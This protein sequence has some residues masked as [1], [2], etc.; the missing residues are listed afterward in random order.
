MCPLFDIFTLFGKL[1]TI[2]IVEELLKLSSV[3]ESVMAFYQLM[4]F[5]TEMFTS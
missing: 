2:N 3:S 4:K 1:V 5:W